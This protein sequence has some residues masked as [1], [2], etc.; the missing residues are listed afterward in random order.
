MDIRR[1][2]LQVLLFC[3]LSVCYAQTPSMSVSDF[4]LDPL[5]NTAN[6]EGSIVRDPNGAKCALIKVQT[7]IKG[8][9]FESGMLFVD[10]KQQIGEVWVYVQPGANRLSISH[11]NLGKFEYLLPITL[12]RAKTYILTLVA[13]VADGGALQVS[14]YPEGSE[15]FLDGK[16]YGKTPVYIPSLPSGV[17]RMEI[18]KDGF[19]TLEKKINVV[20]G[21]VV[22]VVDTLDV[23]VRIIVDNDA[24]I[25]VNNRKV[26][27]SS[28]N[29]SLP[30][31]THYL[32]SRK[33]NHRSVSKTIEI[34]GNNE[35]NIKLPSPTPI[36]GAL[37]ITSYPNNVNVKID[38]SPIGTTPCEIN[39]IIIG[40]HRIELSKSDYQTETFDVTV[41][42]NQQAK[43]EK[44]L[45]NMYGIDF[46]SNV[47]AS[48][49]VNKDCKGWTPVKVSLPSGDY[50]IKLYATGYKSYKKKIHVGS[51][52]TSHYINLKRL[53][54]F[55]N[56]IFLETSYSFLGMTTLGANIGIYMN[57]FNF[58][59]GYNWGLKESE[60]IYLS[61]ANSGLRLDSEYK[62]SGL[63]GKFGYGLSI[64]SNVRITPQVGVN[65]IIMS[66]SKM[67]T[68]HTTFYGEKPVTKA[69]ALSGSIGL[70]LELALSD[71]FSVFVNPSFFIPIYES[72]LSST[73]SSVSKEIK[74]YTNGINISSGIK[75]YIGK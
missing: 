72:D 47:R 18:K 36:Y 31:G 62:P 46:S 59:V 35:N 74:G 22:S 5:D 8:F 26:G 39:Q 13:N 9:S 7:S 34:N 19:Q 60:T 51:N 43:I 23:S 71:W 40:Q 65:Y 37:K 69:D 21:D 16:P 48:L 44:T 15:V 3:I 14:V 12:E 27:I 45:N 33:I 56:E 64:S 32:E 2:V 28:W 11:E 49:F 17:W 25:Y 24:D 61:N 67:N 10:T 68:Y 75:I 63:V 57:R 4:H 29:G 52:K 6:I 73:L 41:K 38:G 20:L 50:D 55:D 70:K 42:E 1:I 58:E 30:M 54:L 66:S 53:K